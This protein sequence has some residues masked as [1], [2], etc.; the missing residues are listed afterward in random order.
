MPRPTL[1]EYF[2]RIAVLVAGRSTCLHRFQ[3][4]VLVK[5]GH[6][7]STGYNGAPPGQKHCI[8]IG[9][10]AK[11]KNQPCRA[12][13]LHGE[14]NAI[15]TAARLGVSVEGATMYSVYSPC[16]TCCN[17]MAAAGITALI[18]EKVYENFPEGLAYLVRI[19]VAVRGV[20]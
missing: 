17:I 5:D 7:L 13:G 19:G 16:L 2:L 6:I 1:D 3:G 12:V 18:C 8:D 20:K 9:W 10:C 4:A 15:V 11:E 14:S